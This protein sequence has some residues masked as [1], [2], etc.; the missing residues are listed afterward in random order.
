MLAKPPEHLVIDRL[1]TPIGIALV[2]VDEDGFLRAFDWA[3]YGDRQTR[4]LARFSGGA[5]TTKTGAAPTAIRQAVTDYFDG[6]LRALEMAP[7]RSGGTEFQLKCWEAL[8]AI[9]AGSTSSYGQ[10]AVKI[11]KPSAMRAVGLAN[12]CNPV[13]VIVPCHRVI[14]ANGSITGYGGGLWRKRW[15]LRHEGASF[16]DDVDALEA[17]GGAGSTQARL[18]AQA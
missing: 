11:G 15:L 5:P 16:R 13:G 1:E 10:Q 18:L 8:C 2:A 3:D 14:G 6:D 4:L 9:P 7:W 12:G 17:R